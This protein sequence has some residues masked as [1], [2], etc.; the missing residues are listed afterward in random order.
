MKKRQNSISKISFL[1]LM[2]LSLITG[3]VS[4]NDD[5]STSTQ[6]SSTLQQGKW[7]VEDINN[8]GVIDRL[9]LVITFA[10]DGRVFGFAGCN[11]FTGTYQ[12][13]DQQLTMGPLAVTKKAC[14]EAIDKQENRFVATL[15]DINE[16][17]IAENGV[18]RLNAADG[19]S[20]TA[21]LMTGE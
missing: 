12:I 21:T 2:S 14:I 18:L 13:T 5:K 7:L 3:C 4:M 20:I 19:R 16:F 17:H 1:S 9:Q 10:E 15:S 11:N 8:Q 6:T